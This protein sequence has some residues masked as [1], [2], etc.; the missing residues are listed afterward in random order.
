MF[1]ILHFN[2]IG[3]L[4]NQKNIIEHEC[5]LEGLNEMKKLTEESLIIGFFTRIF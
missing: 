4:S 1:K 3:Q 2:A 5:F